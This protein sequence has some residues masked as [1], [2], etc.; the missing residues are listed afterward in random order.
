[1]ASSRPGLH[2]GLR[3]ALI[4]F[5]N[6]PRLKSSP[7]PTVYDAQDAPGPQLSTPDLW[8]NM[9]VAVVLVLVGGVFAGLT[10]ACVLVMILLGPT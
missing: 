4:L 7:L 2:F 5:A 9:S 1:M 8:F 3:L 6:F 10:I